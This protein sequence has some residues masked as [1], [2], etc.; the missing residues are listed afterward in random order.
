[1]IRL[2]IHLEWNERH[3]A[4]ID[5]RLQILRTDTLT[6]ANL[7]RLEAKRSQTHQMW[8][9]LNEFET[10]PLSFTIQS[11]DNDLGSF[12]LAVL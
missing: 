1:M 5:R 2:R 9:R 4:I 10:S 6:G 7:F 11:F 8:I 3:R 12:T